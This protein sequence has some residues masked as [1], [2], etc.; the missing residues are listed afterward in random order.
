[1]IDLRER[2]MSGRGL[3]GELPEQTEPRAD[4][5]PR[6]GPRLREPMRDQVELRAV[7]IDS[8]IGQD[9]RARVI[10]AYVEGL[11]PEASNPRIRAARERAARE[12]SERVQTA[13]KALAEIKRKRK[14]LGEK[15]GN[16]KKPKEPR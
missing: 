16:G 3:F 10:W 7:D 5:A 6:G 13:Q 15:G 12:R 4:A 9:H 14:Q 11:E 2:M 1:M 8:L